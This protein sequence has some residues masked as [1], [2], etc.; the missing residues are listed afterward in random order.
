MKSRTNQAFSL[1]EVMIVCAIIS[2]LAATVTISY[3]SF[4][5]R[6]NEITVKKEQVLIRAAI[7]NFSRRYSRYPLSIEELLNSGLIIIDD[8]EGNQQ[9][10]LERWHDRWA[11]QRFANGEIS[12]V[13]PKD[14]EARL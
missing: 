9:R 1:V 6:K 4:T 14:C 13:V 5:A 3:A 10:A 2:I 8:I 7:D 11:A 12:D